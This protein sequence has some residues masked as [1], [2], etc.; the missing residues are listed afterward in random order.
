MTKKLWKDFFVEI[1][2]TL[3]RYLSILFIVALGV[4]F[5]FRR[6][7]IRAGYAAVCGCVL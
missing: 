4:A 6:A 7:G 1:R 3:P 5:F 2:K